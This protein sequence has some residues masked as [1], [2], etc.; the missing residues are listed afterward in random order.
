MPRTNDSVVE[1]FSPANGIRFVYSDVT[2]V[3][4]R[5]VA[6]HGVSAAAAP[7]F[8]RVLACAA[9]MQVDF[10]DDDETLVVSIDVGG[11]FGGFTIEFDG[12]GYLRGAPF[13]TRPDT[14][15]NPAGGDADDFFGFGARVKATR[16]KREDGAIRSQMTMETK[17]DRS[18]APETLFSEILSSAIPSRICT[19]ASA[20]IGVPE[21]VRALAVQRVPGGSE[22]VFGRICG[23]VDD[24]TLAEQLSSDPTL[25]A[26]RD[27]LDLPDLF[28]G[29]TRAVDFG[30]TCSEEKILAAWAGLPPQEI[31][32]FVRAGRP[33]LFRCHL[34]GRVWEIPLGKIVAAAKEAAESNQ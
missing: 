14:I 7:A 34:C 13:E 26:M 20:W 21:R 22:Q 28:S 9:L 5:L 10:I 3:A 18:A 17:P 2:G 24:G 1:A 15:V 33:R 23:L 31:I 32:G 8:G 12:C 4:R 6:G 19:S 25:D 30:C 27:V 16:M 11:R 29:P